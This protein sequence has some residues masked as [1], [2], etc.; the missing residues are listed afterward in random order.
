MKIHHLIVLDESGSMSC[1]R[2]E[3]IDGCNETLAG[4]RKMQA[5][6]PESEQLVS[7]YA[8]DTTNS[9]YIAEDRPIGQMSDITDRDYSPCGCTPLF[10][11][12]GYTLTRLKATLE[13]EQAMAYVTVITDGEENASRTYTL[14]EVSL[15][16]KELKKKEVIFSFIGANIDAKEYAMQ[17]NITNVI[18]FSQDSK[19]TQEMWRRERES[20]QRSHNRRRFWEK[21]GVKD[22]REIAV[23]ENAGSYYDEM[24]DHGRFTPERI[25]HLGA[26]EVFVF[27]SNIHGDHNGGA[28]EYALRHFGAVMGQAEGR[29]GQSYAIPTVGVSMHD[30]YEAVLRFVNYARLHQEL[31]FLVTAIGCGNA[32][33]PVHEVAM[34][35]Y[36]ARNLPNVKLPREFWEK[37]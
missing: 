35:F 23:L 29:Q 30:V 8:F 1:V 16:I 9:R 14:Q 11:A 17:L 18:Q 21:F 19:G 32:G 36:D 31:T 37:V 26:N 5:D 15:L 28:A 3:T 24:R 12:L 27:G 6:D 4:I 7:I 2:K 10:D 22:R 33:L 34:M 20:K 25:T 13:G